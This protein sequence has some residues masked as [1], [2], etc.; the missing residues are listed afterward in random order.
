M[1]ADLRSGSGSLSDQQGCSSARIFACLRLATVQQA[2]R[3]VFQIIWT[4]PCY[5]ETS[6]PSQLHSGSPFGR[7]W[8]WPAKA[9]AA[10][11]ASKCQG[12]LFAFWEECGK[13]SRL[14][15][16]VSHSDNCCPSSTE[17]ARQGSV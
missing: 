15:Q 10:A 16:A 6:P 5:A 9:C 8:A 1:K 7:P 11:G 13:P 12:L 4:I 14:S 2:H 3:L 17:Q